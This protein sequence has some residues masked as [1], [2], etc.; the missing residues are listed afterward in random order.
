MISR[1]CSFLVIAGQG[2]W[3]CS[4]P[5][6]N[7][8]SAATKSAIAQGKQV[9]CRIHRLLFCESCSRPYAGTLWCAIQRRKLGALPSELSATRC[10]IFN[11]TLLLCV[12]SSVTANELQQH[13]PSP[14]IRQ[15]AA[16]SCASVTR[17]RHLLA[18]RRRSKLRKIRYR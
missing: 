6:C 11:V 2:L 14:N 15:A 13:T 17:W 3:R 7:V 18:I 16:A 12:L 5:A 9:T 10:S 1:I 4:S 8:H